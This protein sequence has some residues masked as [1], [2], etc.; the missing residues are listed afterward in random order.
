[1]GVFKDPGNYYCNP[2]AK[3]KQSYVPSVDSSV[4]EFLPVN[5]EAGIEAVDIGNWY[6][7]AHKGEVGSEL[8]T[9]L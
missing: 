5:L 7:E 3:A 4:G 9:I 6:G 1:M 2:R 8:D